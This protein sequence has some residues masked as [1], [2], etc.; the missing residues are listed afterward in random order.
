VYIFALERSEPRVQQD[1]DTIG[2]KFVSRSWIQIVEHV[3]PAIDSSAPRTA[4]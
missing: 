3:W 2:C 1:I 4:S